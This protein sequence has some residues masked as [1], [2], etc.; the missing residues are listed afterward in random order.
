MKL[1]TR[2]FLQ[3]TVLYADIF[4]WSLTQEELRL[5]CIGIQPKVLPH[6]KNPSLSRRMR[7]RWAKKKW[8]IAKSAA[9]YLRFIPS[10]VLVGVTGGLSRNNVKKNDD[11]DFF[12]ITTSGTL[13]ISRL[14]AIVVVELLGKRRRPGG[15][16]VADK[17]CLNMFMSEDALAITQK[18]RDLF[19][20]YEVLQMEPL[21]ERAGAY[22]KFLVKNR[23]VKKFLPNAWEWRV[24]SK[25]LAVNSK[26]NSFLFFVIEPFAR[27]IQLWYMKSRRTSEVIEPGVLRFHPR[28]AR[29]WIKQAFGKR[30]SRYNIPLDKI[31]YAR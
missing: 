1:D 10:I 7:E 11:I 18:E 31:F 13:W 20:A 27:A 28:D 14:L 5:W 3:A 21:W 17:I 26:R 22:K 19:A 16:N 29:A 9:R 2:K 6:T 24:N 4:D 23:W 25:Q 15:T 8:E 30:L 12:C